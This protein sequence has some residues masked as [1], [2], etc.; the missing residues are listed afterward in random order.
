MK[1]VRFPLCSISFLLEEVTSLCCESV[2]GCQLLFDALKWHQ[3]PQKRSTL[4]VMNSKFR[5][6]KKQVL[7]IGGDSFGMSVTIDAYNLTTNSWTHFLKADIKNTNF[8]AVIYKSNVFM[9]GGWNSEEDLNTKA[10]SIGLFTKELKHLA[11]MKEKR[12]YS[13]AATVNHRIFIMGGWNGKNELKIVEEYD[14]VNNSWKNVASMNIERHDHAS[15]VYNEEI[16][17]FGGENNKNYLNSVEVFNTKKNQWKVLSP[18]KWKRRS[19][20]AVVV[21]DY[22]YCI[23]GLSDNCT[24]SIIERYHPGSD[25]WTEVSDLPLNDYA[26]SAISHNGKIVY[27][28]GWDSRSIQEYDFANEQWRII[29]EMPKK[30]YSAQKDHYSAL[31]VDVN[32]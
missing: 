23:G 4:P 9:F 18:M 24:M 1:C 26:H 14:Y 20:A 31:I 12:S 10:Y 17:V 32:L 7:I 13:T 29:G 5:M 15:V 22:I 11:P 8:S 19:L 25:T 30:H 3:M 6:K 21:D 16:Y 27:F 2:E 28:G